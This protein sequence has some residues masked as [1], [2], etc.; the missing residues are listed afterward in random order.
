MVTIK[1]ATLQHINFLVD[2]QQRL[3]NETEGIT[4]SPEIL[5]T[6]LSA[7]FEDPSKGVYYVA[8]ADNEVVGCHMTTTEWS[9][10]RNGT[11]LWIQS[12]YVLKSYR[13]CGVFKEMY[14][15]LIDM[16]NNNPGYI[17]LRLY[18]DKSNTAAMKLYEAMGMDGS[19][20]TMYEWMK[21]SQES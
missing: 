11:V 1:K 15:N 21:V 19:H 16:I 5:H 10:W 17:G 8:L 9:E 12:L 2:F 14:K 3:A 7:M 4:L 20:Y 6:G 18:V 13:K